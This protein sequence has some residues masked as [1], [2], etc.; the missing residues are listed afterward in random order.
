MSL[1][2]FVGQEKVKEY[3]DL[4]CRAA[5][6]GRQFPHL[7]IYGPAGCGKTTLG[8]GI[9]AELGASFIYINATA[10][11]TPVVFREPIAK[12]ISKEG[13]NK[14]FIILI[15]EAHALS[16]SLQDSL[17]SVL[18]KPALL[19]TPLP[20]R[21]K[22]PNG[23]WAPKG[24]IIKEKLPD[25]IT[26][27]F[28][29]TDKGELNEPL[30][31]RLEPINLQ[32]YSLEEKVEFVKQRL[33]KENITLELEDA[34]LIASISKNMRH[35]RRLT[36]RLGDFGAANNVTVL[37]ANNV[38]KVIDMLGMDKWGC[39][40]ADRKYLSYIKEH[41]PVSLDSIARYLNVQNKEVKSKIEPFL[42]RKEWVQV[43]SKG[44][45]ITDKCRKEKYGEAVS[46]SNGEDI[47]DI[48][49]PM[50]ED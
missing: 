4:L 41:G 16:S 38:S 5:Q 23:K 13:R 1:S 46:A 18:E 37:S 39:D 28:A 22:L 24:Y 25:N 40:E 47:L 50:S 43:T 32:E 3:I 8:E 27:M 7:G 34:Q 9:A 2:D 12:A 11:K 21:T 20:K 29:T 10:V 36:Q 15:D 6:A 26:F 42:I 33:I 48:L 19:C 35:L 31:T 45:V 17:L 44:R 49:L 14:Q 30:T